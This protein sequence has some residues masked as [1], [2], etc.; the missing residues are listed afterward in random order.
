MNKMPKFNM[1][2]RWKDD[3]FPI[4]MCKCANCDNEFAVPGTSNEYIPNFCPY[5][6]KPFGD[7][8]DLS[9]SLEEADDE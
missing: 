2:D 5:C 4:F 3:S 7:S 8:V 1:L 9:E 6:G